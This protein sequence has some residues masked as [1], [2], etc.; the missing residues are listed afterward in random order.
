MDKENNEI[1]EQDS[2]FAADL[3]EESTIFA[4][5][6]LKDNKPR[7]KKKILRI[8]LSV[9]CVA[10]LGTAIA[11]IIK[12][13]PELQKEPDSTDISQIQIFGFPT[14]NYKQIKVTNKNGEFI[15]NS[16]GEN[17][18]DQEAAWT[19]EG[20]DSEIIGGA[21]VQSVVNNTAVVYAS[22]ALENKTLEE[23]GLDDPKTKVEIVP[24][25]GNPF[26]FIIGDESLDGSGVYVK[27]SYDDTIFLVES[28]KT[29]AFDFSLLNL[30]N[31]TTLSGF[32]VNSDM[33]DYKDDE[34]ALEKFDKMVISGP[35]FTKDVVIE[36]DVNTSMS[37]YINY[38]VTEPS[39]R[40]A[41]N[42]EGLFDMFKNGIT[43]LAAYSIDV[44]DRSIRSVGLH[45][46]D[47]CVTMYIKNYSYSFKFKKQ[48]DGY[49]AVISDA[50]KVIYMISPEEY[51][52][53]SYDTLD[54]YS[55]WVCMY[56]IEDIAELIVEANGNTY[57]FVLTKTGD[58]EYSAT[59]NGKHMLYDDFKEFYKEC[60]GLSVSNY[61]TDKTTNAADLKLTF[62][63][64]DSKQGSDVIEFAPISDIKHQY[65]LNGKI[66]GQVNSLNLKKFVQN[67]ENIVAQNS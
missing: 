32:P 25:E 14:S 35:N 39:Y 49:Y 36:R 16:S 48:I 4:D 58:N 8:I 53:L 30:V 42:T 37:S 27:M 23:C 50:S 56:Y 3:S 28:S 18:E 54:F 38:Y 31:T 15:F 2:G 52:F 12:F 45:V 9:L 10:L 51:D 60:I 63:F 44:T 22:R 24:F 43:P 64:T 61:N 11:L 19:V 47:F 66:M 33:S 55:K 1:L 5:P 21:Q 57:D 20:Y 29:S 6:A 62:K 7:K 17:S 13:I 40:I 67:L 59:C 65:K 41:Q 34:G 46:P 26:H